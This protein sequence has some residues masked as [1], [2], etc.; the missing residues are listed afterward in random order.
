M[1]F[2]ISNFIPTPGYYVVGDTPRYFVYTTTDSW[3]DIDETPAPNY[4]AG[5]LNLVR[6]GDFIRVVAA[7]DA[8][9]VVVSGA[10]GSSVQ[11]TSLETL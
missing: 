1:A 10:S 11:I 8:K 7:D 2:N 9:I 4:F 6:V 3:F 5:A